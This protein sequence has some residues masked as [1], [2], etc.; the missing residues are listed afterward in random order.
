MINCLLAL[1]M[2]VGSYGSADDYTIHSYSFDT[3]TGSVAPIDSLNG[4]S[5]PSFLTFADGG[6]TL[7]TVNEDEGATAGVT[8]LRS[9]CEGHYIPVAYSPTSADGS[10]VGAAPCHIAVTPDGRH[11]VTANYLGG[12]IS[13]FDFDSD[14]GYL[15]T[16]TVYTY[17]GKGADKER[18][19]SPHPHFTAF[20][21]DGKLMVVNDLGTDC[22]Y[23]YMMDDDGTP[24]IGARRDVPLLPGSGPRHCVFLPGEYDGVYHGYLIN[25]IDGHVVWFKYDPMTGLIIPMTR[26]LA[27]FAHGEGSADIHLSPDGRFVYVSNRLKGDGIVTFSINQDDFS[28]TPV[29]FTPTGA[30]PRNFA[31][32]PDGNWLVVACRDA[33]ALEVYRRDGVS[34]GLTRVG[35]PIWCPRPV[36][37]LFN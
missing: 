31:L 12:S 7:L 6:A 9:D 36:C 19:A 4:V 8:M 32:T 27:D 11:A 3:L 21:P 30:H 37:V 22:I 2:T 35:D 20:T 18:Q 24:M 16:P 10:T 17:E 13:L 5:N 33:N 25:E 28:L 23:T 1:V 26:T 29:G 14:S 15:S 34:G